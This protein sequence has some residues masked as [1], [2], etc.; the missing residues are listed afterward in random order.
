[1]EKVAG[2]RASWMKASSDN[3]KMY[4]L[5][6]DRLCEADLGR[7]SPKESIKMINTGVQQVQLGLDSDDIWYMQIKDKSD[8]DGP[9]RQSTLATK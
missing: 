8:E 4:I 1:M 3:R 9:R 6:G 2:L 7:S 5:H